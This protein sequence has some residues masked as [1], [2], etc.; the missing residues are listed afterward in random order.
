MPLKR[1]SS[2]SGWKMT[3]VWLWRISSKRPVG[4]QVHAVQR[5]DDVEMHKCG[6]ALIHQLGLFL[7]IE[8]LAMLRMMRSTSR[9]QGRRVGL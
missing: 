3:L 6:T 1:G 4:D 9:C 8:I 2:K 5:V 7:R